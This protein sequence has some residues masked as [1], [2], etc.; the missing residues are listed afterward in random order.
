MSSFFFTITITA[1]AARQR[2]TSPTTL[3]VS[4]VLAAFTELLFPLTVVVP[5]GV[6][7]LP[8]FPEP[9]LEVPLLLPPFVEP[10]LMFSLVDLS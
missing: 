10:L 4:P 7:V 1:P 2:T 8:L 6:L 5:E 9:V 3:V